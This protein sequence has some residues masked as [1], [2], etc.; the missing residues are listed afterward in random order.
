MDVS[1]KY[2]TYVNSGYEKAEALLSVER[3]EGCYMYDRDGNKYMDLFS[4]YA[5]VNTGHNNPYVI[6]AAKAQLEKLIH[7]GSL[8]NRVQVVADL[9]ERLASITPGR[10]QKSFFVN[11]GAEANEGAI[12]L[13]KYYTGR[14]D[15]LAPQYGYFG[16][17][18]ASLSV[19]GMSGRK[20]RAGGL[21]PGVHFVPA[22]YCYRCSLDRTYPECD[23]QCANMVEDI[24]RLSSSGNV[25]ALI[26]ESVSGAGGAFAAPR[27]YFAR[28]KQILDKYGAILII[29]EVQAG[30]GRT[31]KMW[32]VEHYGVEPE[33]MTISKGIAGGLPLGAF[34]ATPEV[35]ASLGPG[36]YNSTFGGSP[37]SCAAAL[38]NLDV[39][40][41]EGLVAAA[42]EKGE[43]MMKLLAPL[44]DRHS[45]VGDVRGIGLFIGIEL[46][47]DEAKTPANAEAAAVKKECLSRGIS[48]GVGGFYQN[49]LRVSPP[50]IITRE[51]MD[52]AAGVIDEALAVVSSKM[53]E[54]QAGVAAR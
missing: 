49:I 51:E 34:I 32:G 22:P 29:D 36:D 35:A 46:V 54:V 1:A 13:A 7:C 38:A 48:I 2:N 11:S 19:V 41:R 43:H 53:V 52:H 31:G 15:I 14:T 37:I 47:K 17:T 18:L 12:R 8:T 21:M 39:I 6:E 24:I 45:L 44:K 28:V 50:L 23:L 33:I 9:A 10:L 4:S 25:A 30:M 5:V 20:R 40:E 16:R 42:G 3:A 27:G 26:S